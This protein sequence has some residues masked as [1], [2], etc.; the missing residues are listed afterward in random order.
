MEDLS[1]SMC[2][3]QSHFKP[4]G[5]TSGGVY[6]PHSTSPSPL[7]AGAL[8]TMGVTSEC[9][10]LRGGRKRRGTWEVDKG[11]GGGCSWGTEVREP[12]REDEGVG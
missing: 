9:V 11:L 8:L 10:P 3:K 2:P 7:G 4:R 1:V 6:P 12:T 5:A